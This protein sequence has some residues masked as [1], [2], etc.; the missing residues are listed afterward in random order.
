MH[1]VVFIW[2]VELFSWLKQQPPC[3][4]KGKEQPLGSQWGLCGHSH[5][6]Y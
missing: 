4:A 1:R 5:G 2:F 6:K 3:E